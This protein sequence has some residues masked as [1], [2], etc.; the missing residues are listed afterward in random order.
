MKIAGK[1]GA[2]RRPHCA[3][4]MGKWCSSECA[5]VSVSPDVRCKRSSGRAPACE[6]P[7]ACGR[8][9]NAV[10]AYTR[11]PAAREK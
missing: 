6:S 5:P 10:L 1:G 7:Q 9:G 11:E 2:G 3:G 4:S 8:R